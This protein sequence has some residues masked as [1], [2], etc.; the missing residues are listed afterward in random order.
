MIEVKT[1]VEDVH[2]VCD[3]LYEA[4]T[5]KVFIEAN[6]HKCQIFVDGILIDLSNN[7]IKPNK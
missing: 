5:W 3:S 1:N 7:L 2:I 4:N 6:G